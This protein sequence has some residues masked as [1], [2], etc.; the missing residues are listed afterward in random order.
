M[1]K[2]PY[3]GQTIGGVRTINSKFHFSV[4][5]GNKEVTTNGISAGINIYNPCR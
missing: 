2:A 3:L 1:V 4:L 5:C